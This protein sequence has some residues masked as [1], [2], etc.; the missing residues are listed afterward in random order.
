[1][2]RPTLMVAAAFLFAS[3]GAA[4]VD[5]TVREGTSM[6]VAVSPDGRSLAIDLQGSIWTLPST[7]GVATRITRRPLETMAS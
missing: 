3:H 4:T 5:V 1:V 7:G 2:I 6:A